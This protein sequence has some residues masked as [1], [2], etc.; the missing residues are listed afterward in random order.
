MVKLVNRVFHLVFS[1]S[2]AVAL[3]MVDY[4]IEKRTYSS[5][6]ETGLD[7]LLR[8][9]GVKT[10]YIAGLHTNMCNRHTAADAF[11]RGYKVVALQDGEEA[12]TEKDHLEGL[13]YMKNV[14]NAEV[15]MVKEAITD[16]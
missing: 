8:D 12:F 4:I 15:K 10:L 14:Y 13:E 9:M 3:Y 7:L 5:F 6:F 1:G 2:F 16:F 11:F